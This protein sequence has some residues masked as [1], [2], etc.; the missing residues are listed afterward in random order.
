MTARA[1]TRLAVLALAA[2]PAGLSAQG[3]SAQEFRLKEVASVTAVP[4]AEIEPRTILFSDHRGDESADPVTGLVRFEDWERARPLEK[5]LL[6]LHPAYVEPTV[7]VTLNGV[8]KPYKK[9]LHMYVAEARFVLAKPPGAVNLARFASLQTLQKIDP[10]IRHKAMG[11]ADAVPQKDPEA[12]FNRHPDRRWCEQ[13]A[14]C[15]ESHY[16]L[17]GKLPMGIRL[18]NKL[19]EGGKKIAESIDFQSEIRV[20]PREEA[21]RPALM[22]LAGL[23][24][25][26]AGALEQTLFHVNQIMTFGKLLAVVQPHPTD[27]G[28]SVV[29]AFM[30]LGVKSDV[31]EKKKEFERV[32][33]LRNMVP[34]QVLMGNSSFNT[35]TSISAGLPKYV[36]NRIQAIAGILERE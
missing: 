22:R 23:D 10:S 7:N 36:R 27:P 9:K 26:V 17:E 5:Q 1:L 19:E 12:A 31:L 25:P 18:A 13:P 20:L 8:T 32:P 29:T 11:P 16:D 2:A 34:A 15:V 30:A 3:V 6:A 35:G 28:K 24:R 4:P 33:V 14:V 21:A